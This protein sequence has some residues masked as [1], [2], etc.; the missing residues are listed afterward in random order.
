MFANLNAA[1]ER[2][3][4]CR[5]TLRES[6]AVLRTTISYI[7]LYWQRR[8]HGAANN[9]NNVC[10]KSAEYEHVNLFLMCNLSKHSCLMGSLGRGFSVETC[11]EGGL[12][13]SQE[14]A[15]FKIN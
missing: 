10:N 1:I 14:L 3:N 7:D 5:V 4:I 12:L 8:T 13:L 9:N 11:P 2:H 6:A 15:H